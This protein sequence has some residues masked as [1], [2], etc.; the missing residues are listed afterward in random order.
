MKI[1]KTRFILK[2][3]LGL[4]LSIQ[5]GSLYAEKITSLSMSISMIHKKG[6]DGKSI[7][8]SEAHSLEEI[9]IDQEAAISIRDGLTLAFKITPTEAKSEYLLKGTASKKSQNLFQEI[10]LLLK[11]EGEVQK[12]FSFNENQSLEL[13]AKILEAH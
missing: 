2:L 12:E 4:F 1:E 8:L 10:E 13:K 7:L 9:R 11:V 5:S 3:L 6:F